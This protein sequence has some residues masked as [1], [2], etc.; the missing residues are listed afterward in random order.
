MNET[1][2]PSLC[3][4]GWL[5]GCL[6]SCLYGCLSLVSFSSVDW[7]TVPESRLYMLIFTTMIRESQYVCVVHVFLFDTAGSVQRDDL[8][9][10]HA[11]NIQK[12]RWFVDAIP[13]RSNAAR[14]RQ[15]SPQ[16]SSISLTRSDVSQVDTE[17]DKD[18]W[19]EVMVVDLVMI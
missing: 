6:A 18:S 16:V 5:S 14:P 3:L 17:V 4:P 15:E 13:R 11:R 19:R 9:F 2:A 12:F 1:L 7:R 8:W 10:V